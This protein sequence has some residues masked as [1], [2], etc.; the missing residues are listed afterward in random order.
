MTM[1]KLAITRKR[2]WWYIFMGFC[3]SLTPIFIGI[4]FYHYLSRFAVE[5]YIFF[6]ATILLLHGLLLLFSLEYGSYM[7]ISIYTTGIHLYTYSSKTTNKRPGRNVVTRRIF[8]V[9]YEWKEID[10]YC[11]TG[12]LTKDQR[13][14]PHADFF[15]NTVI[16]LYLSNG[17]RY[18]YNL[19][20]AIPHTFSRESYLVRIILLAAIRKFSKGTV[21]WYP[22]LD[23][24]DKDYLSK[25]Y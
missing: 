12:W 15:G 10:G 7:L 9:N 3:L 13:K 24:Q 17:Y 21:K 23:S 1:N 8:E 18:Y 22:K 11:I 20:Q 16:I 6:W 25:K 19:T 5:M 4:P 2:I 14:S